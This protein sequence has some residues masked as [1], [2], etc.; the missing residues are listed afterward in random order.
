L[1]GFLDHLLDKDNEMSKKL[2]DKFVFKIIPMINPDGVF[3][4]HYRQDTKGLNLNRYYTNP[5]MAT[6]PSIYASREYVV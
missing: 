4:G 3:R 6:M 2:R 5:S 1:N